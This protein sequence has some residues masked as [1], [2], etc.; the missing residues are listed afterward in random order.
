MTRL[1]P[2]ASAVTTTPVSADFI[3]FID[4]S[5]GHAFKKATISNITA[6]T[7]ASYSTGTTTTTFSAGQLTGG[8]FTCYINT[9]GSPGSISTR[10]A[11]QMFSDYTYARVGG[12]YLLRIVNGQGTGVLTVTAGSNVTLSGTATIATNTWRDF[13]VTFTSDSALT[14]Q[15]ISTG[16]F[17]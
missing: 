3:N 15:G 2:D 11:A 8:E 16:T 4:V 13:I 5:D 14:M 1:P 7:T 17:S 10:T 6:K 9:Q 12:S